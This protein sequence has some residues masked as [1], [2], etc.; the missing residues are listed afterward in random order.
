MNITSPYIKHI[1]FQKGCYLDSTKEDN[2]VYQVGSSLITDFGWNYIYSPDIGKVIDLIRKSTD[3]NF[4]VF[5]E[6][7]IIKNVLL[8]EFPNGKVHLEAWL[9][10]KSSEIQKAINK[11]DEVV[12]SDEAKP[13]DDYLSVFS[14]L[15]SDLGLAEEETT[16]FNSQYTASLKQAKIISGC[17]VNHLVGYVAS[18]P[19]AVASVYFD[20][21]IGALYNVGTLTGQK[22]LGYGR[23]ISELALVEA[24]KSGA[25]SIFLQCEPGGY[26]E[27]LYR[28]IGF[29][30]LSTETGFIEIEK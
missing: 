4:V 23:S 29:S 13:S 19:V 10:I 18:K 16:S 2:G 24:R 11:F 26:V 12:V 3:R 1:Q 14:N 7:N 22:N 17:F 25:K 21:H 6:S 20:E 9:E 28:S 5:F 27:K 15:L 8:S 30:P